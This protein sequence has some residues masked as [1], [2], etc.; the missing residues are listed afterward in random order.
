MNFRIWL[1]LSFCLFSQLSLSG[2]SFAASSL[3]FSPYA[4]INKKST[5]SDLEISAKKINFTALYSEKIGTF[6]PIMIPFTIDSKLGKKLR[7]EL[8]LA[9][10]QHYCMKG[11]DI[12]TTITLSDVKLSLDGKTFTT[13]SKIESLPGVGLP[14]EHVLKINF[15]KLKQDIS[16]RNCYGIMSVLAKPLNGSI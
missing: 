4:T 16:T 7:Y 14:Q 1:I 6:S 9:S 5:N 13:T 8:S 15:P 3:P 11:T 10:S 2:S 12:S